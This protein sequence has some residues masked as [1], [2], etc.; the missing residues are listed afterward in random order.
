MKGK[1]IEKQIKG[2]SHK[3]FDFSPRSLE[4]TI[5]AKDAFGEV[6]YDVENFID[7]EPKRIY[8]YLKEYLDIIPFGDYLKRYIYI[9]AGMDGNYEK[10]DTNEY[11]K[12]IIDSFH[13]CLKQ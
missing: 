2:Y 5:D 13:I 4:F 7:K 1:N 10:V 6:V 3:S 11:Q 8:E 9:I 12:I